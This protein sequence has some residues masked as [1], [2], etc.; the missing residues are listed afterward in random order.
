MDGIQKGAWW[1]VFNDP[2]LDGLERRVAVNNQNIIAA[3]AAYREAQAITSADRASFFPTIGVTGSGTR[4][5]G[6]ASNNGGIITNTGGTTTTTG[7]TGTNS[8]TT[9]TGTTTGTNSGTN[10]TGTTTT[11][12][13]GTVISN[14]A[15][16]TYNAAATASWAPDL[17]GKVRR[18]V[19]SDVASAQAD[20]ASLA[21]LTLSSQTQLAVDYVTLR[22]LDE[23]K[24]PLRSHRGR[25]QTLAADYSEPIQRRGRRARRRH[26][27]SNSA[28][29]RPG[30]GDGHRRAAG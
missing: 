24:R 1:S 16:T 14:R 3:E 5:S 11:T 18:Q 4:V 19:E 7:T 28:N 27:G 12:G 29:Q 23:E 30:A 25:L 26:H 2:V 9:T 20:A 17:W 13:T 22:V 21:N 6:N 10:T 15:S 8:G